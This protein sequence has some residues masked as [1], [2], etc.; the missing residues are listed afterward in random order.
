MRYYRFKDESGAYHEVRHGKHCL[1]IRDILQVTDSKARKM[2]AQVSGC[3]FKKHDSKLWKRY[4]EYYDFSIIEKE[5]IKKE[6]V[7]KEKV[8]KPPKIKAPKIP[9]KKV[10]KSQNKPLK[11]NSKY[12]LELI[13]KSKGKCTDELYMAYLSVATKMSKK[14]WQNNDLI[15]D[16][17]NDAI[18]ICYKYFLKNVDTSQ[19]VFAY[20]SELIKRSFATT[21]NKQSKVKTLYIEGLEKYY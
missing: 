1:M 19:N 21:Y 10:S 11:I 5:E 2:V 7:V 18:I 14:F 6:K 13:S 3:N 16:M 15:E 9:T 17:I 12:L 4:C 8:I 20:L